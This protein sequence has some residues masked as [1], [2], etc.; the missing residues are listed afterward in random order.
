MAQLRAP[1]RSVFF[2][3]VP[4]MIAVT[5][6][7]VWTIPF[8]LDSRLLVTALV[9][10]AALYAVLAYWLRTRKR[11]RGLRYTTPLVTITIITLG[12]I[13][14]SADAPLGFLLFFPAII[15]SSIRAGRNIGIVTAVAAALGYTLAHWLNP[16]IPVVVYEDIFVAVNLLSVAVLSGEMADEERTLRRQ[17]Q[18]RRSREQSALLR[19]ADALANAPDLNATRDAAVEIAAQVLGV[20][21]LAIV[22]PAEEGYVMQAG[23]GLLSSYRDRVFPAAGDSILAGTVASC[24]PIA[25]TDFRQDPQWRPWP[26]PFGQDLRAG[27]AVPMIRESRARGAF[28]AY[29]QKPRVF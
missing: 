5:L 4:L 6:G 7:L 27:L 3:S 29:S 20:D 1:E 28:V 25:V 14:V 21:A 16:H 18:E 26:P 15:F 12:L 23:W 17:D 19:L 2:V 22:A 11:W 9:L 13:K 24:H 8:S 10:V